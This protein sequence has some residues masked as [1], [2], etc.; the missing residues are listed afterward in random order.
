LHDY[1]L[2]HPDENGL[3]DR[4][5]NKL[6]YTKLNG[7]LYI[8]GNNHGRK[9]YNCLYGK[10]GPPSMLISEAPFSISRGYK[11]IV[12]YNPHLYLNY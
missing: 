4:L 2:R 1:N 6:V 3:Y 11:D 10:W 8:S 12:E 5:I 9:L 7:T